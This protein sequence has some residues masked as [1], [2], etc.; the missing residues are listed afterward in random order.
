MGGKYTDENRENL[1]KRCEKKPLLVGHSLGRNGGKGQIVL[2][3]TLASVF[4]EYVRH[5]R[6]YIGEVREHPFSRKE[7]LFYLYQ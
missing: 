6:I 4:G 5:S 1:N 3:W 2:H 7:V